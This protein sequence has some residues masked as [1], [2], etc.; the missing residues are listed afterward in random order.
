L[1]IACTKLGGNF[2]CQLEYIQWDVKKDLIADIVIIKSFYFSCLQVMWNV[3]ESWQLVINLSVYKLG[4]HS[5]KFHNFGAY[6]TLEN[7]L[8]T[9]TSSN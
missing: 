7:D 8:D 3:V 6:K 9:P 1:I 4:I 2:N 5:N